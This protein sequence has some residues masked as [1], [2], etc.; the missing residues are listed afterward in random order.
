MYYRSDWPE[1]GLPAA[2]NER[3]LA[4]SAAR[5]REGPR[6]VQEAEVCGA[7]LRWVATRSEFESDLYGFPMWNLRFEMESAAGEVL[8][9][10]PE[11]PKLRQH[12]GRTLSRMLDSPPWDTGYVC[13]KLVS[14]EPPWNALLQVGLEAVE[15]RRVFRCKVRDLATAQDTRPPDRISYTSL[16]ADHPKQLAI[17]RQ[18]ILG[19]CRESFEESGL[20]RHFVDPILLA[21][22]S[23]IGYILAVMELNFEHVPL[24]RF[25]VAIDTRTDRV[26]GFSAI[27]R[28]P[29]LGETTYTQLLSAVLKTY[30]GQGVYQG[31]TR[32]LSEILPPDATLLNVVQTGNRA[33]QRAYQGTG[34]LYLA[35]TVVLRRVFGVVV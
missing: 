5:Q 29:E 14:T 35:D 18:Q 23:G 31:L 4:D 7:L 25:L 34:R 26:C 33:I 9:D 32:L 21:R 17:R 15:H 19:I 13:S 1:L 3:N 11:N 16:A 8:A 30:R 20:S 2:L 22:L 24:D 12:V 28:K 10:W 27:G 6:W